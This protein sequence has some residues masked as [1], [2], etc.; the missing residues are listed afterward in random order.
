[1]KKESLYIGID[2]GGTKT[3]VSLGTK[4]T[5]ILKKIKFPTKKDP[6]AGEVGHLRIAEEG[7]YCYHKRG[8][9]ESYCSGSGLKELYKMWYNEEKS[10]K[11]ICDLAEYADE[12][13]TC[14]IEQSA[15]HLGKGIALL[16]DIF[17]PD[18]III[19]SIYTRSEH[20]F[21]PTMMHHITLEALPESLNGCTIL[22]SLLKEELGDVAALAV[23]INRLE[24]KE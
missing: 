6:Y 22:P 23:A 19:G 9:W 8:S 14:V 21:F 2:I 24:E 13:A 11:E 20:L 7:P 10:G 5:R 17:D 12:K 18:C 1:M 16:M 3:A 15:T 4:D